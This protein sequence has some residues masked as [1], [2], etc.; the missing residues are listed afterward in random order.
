LEWA[1]GA[2]NGARQHKDAGEA[3]ARQLEVIDS[4]NFSC[5]ISGYEAG[6]SLYGICMR[7]GPYYP[8]RQQ[9]ISRSLR[10]STYGHRPS[11]ILRGAI[12][13]G[14]L[15]RKEAVSSLSNLMGS[16]VVYFQVARPAANIDSDRLPGKG[17]LKDSL[18]GIPCKEE[19]IWPAATESAKTAQ[20]GHGDVLRLVHHSEIE[21][22][23]RS[24]CIVLG[25]AR[26]CAIRSSQAAI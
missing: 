12:T 1:R 9:V 17:L 10:V 2:L 25:H 16:P 24:L 19:C 21:W 14:D 15:G 22:W 8:R 26:R 18:S 4:R 23:R 11:A 5:G 13:V 7:V 6:L 20:L 3:R